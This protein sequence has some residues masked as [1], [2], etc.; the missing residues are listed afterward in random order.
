MVRC[1]D[2]QKL[3]YK[4]CINSEDFYILV[5]NIIIITG[6]VISLSITKFLEYKKKKNLSIQVT[7]PFCILGEGALSSFYSI[8]SSQ[9]KATTS[10]KKVQNKANAEKAEKNNFNNCELK[11][12]QCSRSVE[13]TYHNTLGKLTSNS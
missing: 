8:C 3:F 4:M 6:V 9:P 10:K 2:K 12:N 13:L 7:N 1:P 5:I 11:C